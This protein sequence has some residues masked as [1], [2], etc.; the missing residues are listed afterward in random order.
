MLKAK[1]GKEHDLQSRCLIRTKSLWMVNGN[2]LK[3]DYACFSALR[4]VFAR[5]YKLT[6]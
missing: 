5:A 1:S 3:K 6:R 2:A 4:P